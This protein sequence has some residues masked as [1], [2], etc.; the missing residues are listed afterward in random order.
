MLTVFKVLNK[1]VDSFDSGLVEHVVTSHAQLMFCL[2]FIYFI[3]LFSKG[4]LYEE[5]QEI[6]PVAVQCREALF[7]SFVSR[8]S[9]GML[10]SICDIW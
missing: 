9:D 8:E 6:N 3:H 5:S 7:F 10:F 2:L 1:A 4:L